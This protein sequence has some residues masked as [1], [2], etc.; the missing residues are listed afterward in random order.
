MHIEKEQLLI[1]KH[2]K[3][4]HLTLCLKYSKVIDVAFEVNRVS[5]WHCEKDQKEKHMP[6]H[7]AI[8]AKEKRKKPMTSKALQ[9]QSPLLIPSL[10]HEGT[11]KWVAKIE[12]EKIKSLDLIILA[13]LEGNQGG[14]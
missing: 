3:N 11:K 8:K 7:R 9:P 2:A 14:I 13:H 1:E 4:K 10:M 5:V 6:L 12:F